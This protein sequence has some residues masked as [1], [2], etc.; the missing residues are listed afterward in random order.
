MLFSSRRLRHAFLMQSRRW[1]GKAY[2]QLSMELMSRRAVRSKRLSSLV[3]IMLVTAGEG[4][5]PSK[6]SEGNET[7]HD[8]S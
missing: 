4:T 5:G 7:C 1:K 6:T 8:M 3:S 2:G